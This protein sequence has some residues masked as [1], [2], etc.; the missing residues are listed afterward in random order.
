MNIKDLKSKG[1]I[2]KLTSCSTNGNKVT[3]TEIYLFGIRVYRF[4]AVER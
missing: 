4:C 1:I 2:T 3:S